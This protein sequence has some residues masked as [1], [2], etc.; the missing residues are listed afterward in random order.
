[1]R[2]PTLITNEGSW[3]QE[4]NVLKHLIIQT[5]EPLEDGTESCAVEADNVP[6]ANNKTLIFKQVGCE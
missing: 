1:M 6:A 2:R 5:R 3:F 4:P